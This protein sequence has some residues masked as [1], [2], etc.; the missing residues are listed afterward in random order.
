MKKSGST[1]VGCC[2]LHQER[3]PS[4]HI[5]PDGHYHCYGCGRHGNAITYVME[6]RNMSFPEAVRYLAA[7]E[8]ITVTER[9][10]TEKERA[11]R[12]ETEELYIVNDAVYRN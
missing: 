1:M 7:R 9:E 10:E 12:L 2:P 4:F 11:R 5:Y 8:G 6:K 3:T